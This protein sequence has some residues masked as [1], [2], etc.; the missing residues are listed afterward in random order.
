MSKKQN[1]RR[2]QLE[3]HYDRLS[4]RKMAQVYQVLVP[5]PNKHIKISS[6]QLPAIAIEIK[7][8]KGKGKGKGKDNANA[9]DNSERG[10]DLIED[11]GH[12]CTGFVEQ[13]KRGKDD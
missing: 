5:V 11:N 2:I 10:G 1:G 13:T 8:G 3:Y 12:L 6:L 4:N 7:A 9:N